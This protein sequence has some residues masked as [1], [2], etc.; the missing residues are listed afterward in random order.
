MSCDGDWVAGE[1]GLYD[2]GE[3]DPAYLKT[4]RRRAGPIAV[5]PALSQVTSRVADS[6][7][8]N[9]SRVRIDRGR[10]RDSVE[11]RDQQKRAKHQDDLSVSLH[12]RLH[13]QR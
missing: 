2:G 8:H 6:G 3:L 12:S 5:Q 4:A 1:S 7:D 11:G 9:T 13:D 10:V